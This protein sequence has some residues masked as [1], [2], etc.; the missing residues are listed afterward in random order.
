VSHPLFAP[1]LHPLMA[2]RSAFSYGALSEPLEHRKKAKL[3]EIYPIGGWARVVA[4]PCVVIVVSWHSGVHCAERYSLGILVA[5]FLLLFVKGARSV[6]ASR[7]GDTLPQNMK[8]LKQ[9]AR[10]RHT[11]IEP[12]IYTS[13]YK[14]KRN[15]RT[16]TNA[17]MHTHRHTEE[18]TCTRVNTQR[19][20]Y[21]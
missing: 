13:T 1:V 17:H 10:R 4:V 20:N 7:A 15:Q 6:A 16:Y 19:E 12:N 11:P 8:P 9:C 14:T 5:R 18:Q 3:K 2:R 21:T